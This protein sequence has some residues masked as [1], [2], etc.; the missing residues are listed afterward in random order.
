MR[1]YHALW[2][3]PIT[4]VLLFLLEPSGGE[5]VRGEMCK[6][7]E[8]D[9]LLRLDTGDETVWEVR[10]RCP[11]TFV[12][13]LVKDGRP[14]AG[15]TQESISRLRLGDLLSCR[16]SRKIGRFT[17]MAGLWNGYKCEAVYPLQQK[18]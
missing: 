1:F 17:G 11:S 13:N 9:R 14:L 4:A 12:Q 16:Q 15:T 6:V 5:D 3:I 10:F 2:L 8:I 7:T 18:T